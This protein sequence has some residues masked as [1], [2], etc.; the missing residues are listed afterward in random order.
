DG[1]L[2]T[3]QTME[4]LPVKDGFL[5]PDPGQDIL[6]IAVI[7]RYQSAPPSMGFIRNFGL[8]PGTAIASTVAHD[9]HNIVAVGIDEETLCRAVNALIRVK[10]G[11]VFADASG[12]DV[13]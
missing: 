10:G 1:Q 2:I 11:I 4:Q 12:E 7:N 6:K 8:K 5:L 3:R 9:A 13:L